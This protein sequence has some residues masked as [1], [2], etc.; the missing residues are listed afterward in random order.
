MS[1]LEEH[2]KLG[3]RI[4]FIDGDCAICSRSARFWLTRDRTDTVYVS[5]LQSPLGLEACHQVQQD[6][7]DLDTAIYFEDGRFYQR[8][9]AILRI[10][11]QFSLFYRI[12]ARLGLWVPVSLRDSI[13][14]FIARHRKIANSKLTCQLLPN[15][16]KDRFLS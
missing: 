12:L 2:Q 16:L 13:Y 5:P 14:N 11:L 15:E 7:E 1:N 8:S 6:P 4:I 3:H 9:T 10:C